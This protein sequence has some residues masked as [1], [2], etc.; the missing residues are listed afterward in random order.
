M[1]FPISR[2]AF[3]L[4]VAASACTVQSSSPPPPPEVLPTVPS[5]T[6]VVQWTIDGTTDPNRCN[7]TGAATIRVF[8]TF[9][10][11][12]P[13]GTFEQGCTSFATS[14]SLA[15]GRYTA[16]AFLV[17]VAGAARTTTAPIDAFSIAGNDE[18][19]VPVDFPSSSFF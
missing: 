13:A 6:L 12:S 10:D 5:G 7:A 4:A 11:G 18:L 15:P 19:R 14:I 2:G 17:D 16:G 9:D 3:A 1:R 8:V